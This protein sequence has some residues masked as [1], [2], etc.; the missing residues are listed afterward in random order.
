M[1]QK[2]LH[3]DIVNQLDNLYLKAKLIVEGFMSGLH[4]TRVIQ[5][6]EVA[7]NHNSQDTRAIKP[8]GDYEADNVSKKVL[9]IILSYVNY[10]N[11]TV[12]YKDI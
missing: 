6:V 7:T 1:N 9:R 11:R 3:P 10:V 5:A 2:S 8:V 4:K 12:W